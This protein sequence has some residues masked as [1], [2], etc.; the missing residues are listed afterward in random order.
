M[1]HFAYGANMSRKVMRR[2]APGAQPLGAAQLAGYR[3]FISADGYASLAPC[4]AQMVHGVVWRLTARDRVML[5][6]W[7]NVAAGLYRA[8]VLP[9]R[10]QGRRI[11]A[12]VYLARPGGEGRAK[13]GYVELVIAAGR[14][15]HLPDDYIQALECW[16]TAGRLASPMLARGSAAKIGEFG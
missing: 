5:D 12:L 16:L 4:P 13:P 14:Q 15:W 11:P 3:F 9:V 6:G 10:L 2:Y 7:E 1:L 8:Q